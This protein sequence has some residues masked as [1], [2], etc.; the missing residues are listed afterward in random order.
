VLN[1]LKSVLVLFQQKNQLE[2]KR[3]FEKHTLFVALNDDEEMIVSMSKDKYIEIKSEVQN[4]E[5]L[6]RE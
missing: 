5:I 4:I 3:F 2:N 1:I 6:Y